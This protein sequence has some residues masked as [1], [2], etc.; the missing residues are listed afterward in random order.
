VVV[1]CHFLHRRPSGRAQMHNRPP[2]PLCCR[3]SLLYCDV[4]T[5][6]IRPEIAGE[7]RGCS[8]GRHQAG[9]RG[10][11]RGHWRNGG[12]R[13]TA[14]EARCCS[15]VKRAGTSVS[16]WRPSGHGWR[17]GEA[18]GGAPLRPWPAHMCVRDRRAGGPCAGG[19]ALRTSGSSRRSPRFYGRW[20]ACSVSLAQLRC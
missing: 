5:G 15:L 16:R 3:I 2:A 4:R 9:C 10:L 11:G 20:R 6:G 14:W 1:F 12:A 17:S 8:P 18:R 13:R 19:A 7:V